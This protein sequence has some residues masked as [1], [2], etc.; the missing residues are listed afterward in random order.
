MGAYS[1][2]PVVT[3]EL[4]TRILRSVIEPT[5][6]GMAAE[7]HP[8]LG[9]LYAGLMIGAD[10]VP[11]VLEY[12]CRLGDPETQPIMLRLRSDL[13]DLCE[14]ALDGQLDRATA[15][16]DS[17]VAL[18]VVMT[19][20]GYPGAYPT[21]DIITGLPGPAQDGAKI[22][23][24]GTTLS[25]GDIVTNGGRVLCATALGDTTMEAQRSAYNLAK[26]VHWKGVCFR[27]DIG[28]R[29]IARERNRSH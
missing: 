6:R 19:A 14:S 16:W 10:G 29:A 8:Y 25:N 20:S 24:S 3:P 17:R 7:G 13:V 18:G 21:G 5:V 28:Y 2:A 1:P 11:K 26:R 15:A 9:F 12:N 23:H 27:T 4:H 22:F